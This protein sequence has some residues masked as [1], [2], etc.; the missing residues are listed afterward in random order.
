L[1]EPPVTVSVNVP[2]KQV[3]AETL[4]ANG[5]GARVTRILPESGLNATH[6]N[7][8]ITESVLIYYAEATEVALGDVRSLGV[9][10]Q[11]DDFGTGYSSLGYL[12]RLP[13]DTVKIDRSFISGGR[14]AGIANPQIVQAIVALAWSLGKRVTAEGVETAEQ[15][16]ALQALHC[17]N[18]QGYFVSQPPY[19]DDARTVLLRRR[20]RSQTGA[21]MFSNAR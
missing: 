10:M 11:L 17:T 14:G 9:P 21:T 12:Q 19:E 18:A 2:A 8:E 7:L 3:T 6:L 13:I 16:I 15:L 4:V 5:S 20:G 1:G